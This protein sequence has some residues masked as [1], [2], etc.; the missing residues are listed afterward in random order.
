MA[1]LTITSTDVAP[2]R[3]E[4][5]NAHTD[6][7]IEAVNAGQYVRIDATTGKIALG[8]ATTSTEVGRGGG[9]AIKTAAAGGP[10]TVVRR[11]LVDVGN[12]LNALSYGQVVYLSDTDGTFADSAGTVST[13]IGY[14][15][16]G[17][18]ESTRSKLLMLTINA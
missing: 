8:N 13:I 12:A 7:C 16:P 4:Q 2:V 18:A 5:A 3:Y 14:V 17:A 6:V 15:H 9:I 11:G 10:L 1:N